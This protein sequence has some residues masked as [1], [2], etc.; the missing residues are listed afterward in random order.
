MI[1]AGS[2]KWPL[3]ESSANT[4]YAVKSLIPIKLAG[5][6]QLRGKTASNT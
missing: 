3:L 4:L 2:F 5:K 6:M 1:N